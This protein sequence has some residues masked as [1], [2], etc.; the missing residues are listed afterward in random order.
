MALTV[1]SVKNTEPTSMPPVANYE[2]NKKRQDDA[3]QYFNDHQTEL[4][5]NLKDYINTDDKPK[6]SFNCLVKN[7]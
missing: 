4:I 2:A 5:K 1:S 7:I 6:K 3:E